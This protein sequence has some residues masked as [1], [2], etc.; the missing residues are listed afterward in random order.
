[1]R[2]PSFENGCQWFP[3]GHC[4]LLFWYQ[5]GCDRTAHGPMSVCLIS[6]SSRPHSGT[7]QELRGAP[8]GT[9]PGELSQG[10]SALPEPS[11]GQM[12]SPGSEITRLELQ[13]T[14]GSLAGGQTGNERAK[15]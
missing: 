14:Q 2:N 1:M 8:T 13:V 15:M 11:E 10:H 4:T 3:V 12:E 5:E 7:P 9:Q 6:S